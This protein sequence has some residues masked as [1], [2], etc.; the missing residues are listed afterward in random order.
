MGAWSLIVEVETA[1]C[2][3]ADGLHRNVHT[4]YQFVLPVHSWIHIYD[5]QQMITKIV[6]PNLL[7]KYYGMQRHTCEEELSLQHSFQ[8]FCWR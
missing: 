1:L 7:H 6:R 5:K 3:T 4:Q 2:G 8:L